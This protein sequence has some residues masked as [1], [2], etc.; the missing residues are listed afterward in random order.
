MFYNKKTMMIRQGD[1]DDDPREKLPT[2]CCCYCTT[3]LRN[4]KGEERKE[5]DVNISTL[6]YIKYYTI[7]SSSIFK[8]LY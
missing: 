4:T 2:S 8:P 7:A 1:L 3:N 6:N 5:S